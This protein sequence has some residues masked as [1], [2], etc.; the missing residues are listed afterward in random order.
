MKTRRQ[1]FAGV[2]FSGI[3][4]GSTWSV[5]YDDKPEKLDA[6]VVGK[7]VG[8]SHGDIDTVR[9]MLSETPELIN[10][11]HDWGGG[12]FENGLNAASHVG[13]RDIAE[14]LLEKGA[15]IDV[16][17]ATMLGLTPVVKSMMDAFPKLHAIPGAHKIPLLSHAIF[18]KKQ[19]DEVF[20]LLLESGADVKAAS[21]MNMTPLMAA[22]STGRA[23]QVEE[24]LKRGADPDV[25]DVKNRTALT[26]AEKRKHKDVVSLLKQSARQ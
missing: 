20:V 23:D 17:A 7:F 22:A 13:R 5:Q 10:A 4:A 19:A 15:R 11:T 1:F 14:L 12:D 2:A 8:K 9:K 21:N 6:A 24:L 25:E 3:A 16:C 18:G 26:I